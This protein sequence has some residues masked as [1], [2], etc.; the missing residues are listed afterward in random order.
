[1]IVYFVIIYGFR[2]PKEDTK[3]RHQKTLMPLVCGERGI[4]A[5]PKGALSPS[6]ATERTVRPRFATAT[7]K[8]IRKN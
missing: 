7:K 6:E 4:R 5:R 2:V 1:M 3:K 8:G